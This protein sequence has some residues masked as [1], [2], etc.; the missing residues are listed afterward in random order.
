MLGTSNQPQG[1]VNPALSD[2]PGRFRRA[3]RRF[4]GTN[5]GDDLTA[6]C[7]LCL[8]PRI[9]LITDDV[10]RATLPEV[11]LHPLWLA[12]LLRFRL[13]RTFD[14]TVWCADHASQADRPDVWSQH[15][16]LP[17]PLALTWSEALAYTDTEQ[18]GCCHCGGAKGP[19]RFAVWGADA[20][21][22]T[23][24]EGYCATCM[25]TPTTWDPGCTYADIG[26]QFTLDSYDRAMEAAF[27]ARVLIPAEVTL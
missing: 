7:E 23:W 20:P 15:Y 10:R 14:V 26:D 17:A 5:V 6:G 13:P 8:S 4:F 22:G 1:V 25:A 11:L 12:A 27:P 19:A 21:D 18:P 3:W 16:W 24:G 9:R 2:N